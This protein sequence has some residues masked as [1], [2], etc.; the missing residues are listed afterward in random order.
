M[1]GFLSTID[2]NRVIN[3]VIFVIFILLLI[4]VV[5]TYFFMQDRGSIIHD[6]ASKLQKASDLN[7]DLKRQLARSK[8]PQYIEKEARNRLNMGKQG[9]IV[10]MLPS[11]SPDEEPTPTPFDTSTNL[12]KWKKVFF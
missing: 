3:L 10:I 2:K 7:E 8:S 12:E 1:K 9:E 5:R 6:A 11:I 4:S